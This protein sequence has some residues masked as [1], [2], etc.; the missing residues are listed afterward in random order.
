M[1]LLYITMASIVEYIYFEPTST[2]R[3]VS[4][5]VCI[6]FNLYFIVY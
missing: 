3:I 6:V 5:I 4:A 2:Q 1:S